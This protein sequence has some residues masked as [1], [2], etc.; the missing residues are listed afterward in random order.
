MGKLRLVRSSRACGAAR[1]APLA[2]LALT[3]LVTAACGVIGG[4][5]AATVA[6][7]GAPNMTPALTIPGSRRH[8]LEARPVGPPNGEQSKSPQQVV[9]DAAHALRGTRS[10]AMAA[11]LTSGVESLSFRFATVRPAG[12]AMQVHS[13]PRTATVIDESGRGYV[14]ANAKYWS[15]VGSPA[16]ESLAG[17]WVELPARAT[18]SLSEVIP[19]RLSSRFLGK[20]LSEDHGTLSIAGTST[21]DGEPVVLVRDAGDL[22]GT[23]PGILAVATTGVPYPLRVTATG[24]TRPG[25]RIDQC[26]DGKGALYTGSLTLSR[27]GRVRLP[28]PPADA[29]AEPSPPSA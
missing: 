4:G 24:P 27:F 18:Q 29:I 19:A 11:H 28:R 2:L 14:V 20:C 3:P 25:G 17:R 9:A 7:S 23:G 13:G 8:D 16:L 5:G 21:V 12:F 10:F 6:G 1:R 15:G 26:N 22:P